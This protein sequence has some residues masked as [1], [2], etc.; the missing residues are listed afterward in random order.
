MSSGHPQ[1]QSADPAFSRGCRHAR[2]AAMRRFQ[3][4]RS[5]RVRAA[6]GDHPQRPARVRRDGVLESCAATA[7]FDDYHRRVG[8]ARG[9]RRAA[10]HGSR[11]R[12]GRR[13]HP[14]Q[15]A[16]RSHHSRR[17]LWVHRSCCSSRVSAMPRPCKCS[18][19]RRCSICRGGQKICRITRLR[20]FP[21]ARTTP[22]PRPVMAHP[23]AQRA[24]R[25][26]I[27][28]ASFRA[29]GEQCIRGQWFHAFAPGR[30]S[31]R[32]ADHFHAGR[33][34]MPTAIGC[35]AAMATASSS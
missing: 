5:G 24:H 3:R 11:D 25:R 10:R 6:P 30:R 18:V 27:P 33:T 31:P 13:P 16:P 23:A 15:G 20:Q 22:N 21:C 14:G 1:T 35:R 12:S 29:A 2:P 8:H 34:A 26:A 9:V 19:S 32:S 4:R 28:A 7:E 17:R